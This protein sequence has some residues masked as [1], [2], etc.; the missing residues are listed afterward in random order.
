M[1]LCEAG[2]SLR[3]LLRVMVRLGLTPLLFCPFVLSVVAEVLWT[4]SLAKSY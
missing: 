1:V 3:W 4:G 2:Y